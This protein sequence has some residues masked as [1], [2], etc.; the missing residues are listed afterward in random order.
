MMTNTFS[1]FSILCCLKEA[2]KFG[3][4]S[5]TWQSTNES[6]QRFMDSYYKY[7][8]EHMDIF[9]AEELEFVASLDYREVN[10][11]LK[12]RGFDIQLSP[13]PK[14]DGSIGSGFGVAAVL[15]IMCK[16]EGRSSPLSVCNAITETVYEGVKLDGTIGVDDQNRQVVRFSSWDLATNQSLSAY[17]TVAD[18]ACAQMDLQDRCTNLHQGF[19]NASKLPVNCHFP[20]TEV[21]QEVDISWLLDMFYKAGDIPM[22]ISEALNQNKLSLTEKGAHAQ[23]AAAIGI[24][25]GSMA[26]GSYDHVV[27]DKPFYFWLAKGNC[28]VPI[29][30]AYVDEGSWIKK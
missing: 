6:Q 19:G 18:G 12:R 22:V 23:S 20:K 13:F 5:N 11:F 27:I 21:N 15:D 28:P 1:I 10:A 24:V 30:C 2:L 8:L 29:F 7:A 3:Q 25:S 4:A 16:W 9:T 17:I 14:A 26:A